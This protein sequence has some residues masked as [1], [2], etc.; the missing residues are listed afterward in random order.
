MEF[1]SVRPGGYLGQYRI[2]TTCPDGWRMGI[3]RPADASRFPKPETM[4][5]FFPTLGR[6]GRFEAERGIDSPGGWNTVPGGA[7]L[8]GDDVG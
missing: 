4:G 7:W 5:E 8:R 6:S 2:R 3:V 1:E